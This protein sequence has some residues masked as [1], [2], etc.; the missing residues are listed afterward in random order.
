MSLFF[1]FDLFL[2]AKAEILKNILLVFWSKPWHQK[3]ILKLTDLYNVKKKL[4]NYFFCPWKHEKNTPKS[5][6][7]KQIFHPFRNFHFTAQLPKW[8]NPCFQMWP[9]SRATVCRTGSLS[10]LW[11]SKAFFSLTFVSLSWWSKNI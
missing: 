1:W 8:Q 5:S 2:E 11:C 4:K 7:L 10:F 3:D 6:I 9:I